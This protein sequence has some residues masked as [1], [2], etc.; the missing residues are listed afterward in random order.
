MQ[1]IFTLITNPLMDTGN[2]MLG[3]FAAAF[4]LTPWL[5][6]LQLDLQSIVSKEY[7]VVR[8]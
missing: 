6:A 8:S 7:N 2:K 5:S 1:R 3:L 4:C